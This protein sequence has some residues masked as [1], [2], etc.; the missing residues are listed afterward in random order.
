MARTHGGRSA[1]TS[2]CSNSRAFVVNGCWTSIRRK[3]RQ[4]HGHPPEKNWATIEG[5]YETLAAAST[6][7]IIA[8]GLL[9]TTGVV[10]VLTRSTTAPPRL[11]ALHV[12]FDGQGLRM[13]TSFSIRW[14]ERI[15]MMP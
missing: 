13:G 5:A 14:T 9:A 1:Q 7:S 10:L 3:A 4:D 12:M 8:G 2:L 6:I 11:I 15:W